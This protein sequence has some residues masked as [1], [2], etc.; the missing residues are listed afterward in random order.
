MNFVKKR[1]KVD[2]NWIKNLVNK[3][4]AQHESVF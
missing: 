1:N 4:L 3:I 2:Y